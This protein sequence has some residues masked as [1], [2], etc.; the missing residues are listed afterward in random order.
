MYIDLLL[1]YTN[2]TSI[3]LSNIT[4]YEDNKGARKKTDLGRKPQYHKN[5]E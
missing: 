5:D 2:S 4:E 3:T 1:T